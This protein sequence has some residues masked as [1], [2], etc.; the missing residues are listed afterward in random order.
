[1]GLL[2]WW[3]NLSRENSQRKLEKTRAKTSQ[4]QSGI[5]KFQTATLYDT[6]SMEYEVLKKLK[7]SVY[8]QDETRISS[9]LQLYDGLDSEQQGVNERISN[10]VNNIKNP[11]FR[12]SP[13]KKKDL[14]KLKNQLI[15]LKNIYDGL[16]ESIRDQIERI[17]A[18]IKAND[19]IFAEQQINAA[20][21]LEQNLK[22]LSTQ[23]R[24]KD[25][26]I[27]RL[28]IPQI[29]PVPVEPAP[30]VTP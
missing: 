10:L 3:G 19:F 8:N 29:K 30:G 26:Q 28:L 4:M 11:F 2:K 23:L 22:N 13:K 5:H 6:A 7:E 12:L 14:D 25:T 16:V 20:I 27:G 1:M 17:K 21:K 18:S 24:N 9:L 15:K